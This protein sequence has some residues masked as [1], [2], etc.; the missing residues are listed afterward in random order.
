MLPWAWLHA[1]K[2]YLE[3]AE[4][5]ERHPGM[6]GTINLV[7]SLI[8]QLQEYISG[9]AV[10]PVVALMSKPAEMLTAAEKAFMLDNFFHAQKERLIDRSPRFRELY[11]KANG[12]NPRGH[13]QLED[14]RD[15][16]VQYSLAWTGEISRVREPFKSLVNKDRG[17][18]EEDKRTLAKAQMENVSRIIPLHRELTRRG[19]IEL[20]TSPFYHPI[21]PLL[22]DTES[23]RDAMPDV[24]L[25]THRFQSPEEA[26]EQIRCAREF[27][28]A[29][30][31]NQPDGMWPSEGSLSWDAL[32]LIRKNGFA[33]TATD[34]AVLDHTVHSTAILVRNTSV[35]PQHA[36]YF[37][38]NAKTAEGEIV[39]FFRNHGLS[40]DIGF[41]YPSW[42]AEHATE[43]FVGD[44]LNIR[45]DLLGEYGEDILQ[46]ACISVILDGENCWEFYRNNGYDF[47]DR[48]YSMLCSAPEIQP[49]TFGEV[50]SEA[51][52]DSLP[53]LSKLSAGSWIHGN[54]QIWIGHPEDNAAWD[55]LFLAKKAMDEARAIAR[56]LH[57]TAHTEAIAR[58]EAAHEALKIAEGSDWCWWYGDE[59]VS[60]QSDIFDELYRMHL[61]EVYRILGLNPP[62]DLSHPISGRFSSSSASSRYGAMHRAN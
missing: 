48:L 13:F 5:F 31:G 19:Q 4:H 21:L 11:D 56:K 34:E 35:K 40:D 62:E 39:V 42:N 28:E 2:D 59:N 41:M 60:D 44:I 25:P 53:Q 54:F 1:T 55:A 32:A 27:F 30:F 52:R 57:G 26:Y 7:P 8:K 9:Q 24:G 17:Y 33:W 45:S 14:Y 38:W 12:P 51:K 16:A 22:I 47:L 6:R 20:T 23:A 46:N 49:V 43:H 10:D 50:V 58:I 15:L 37:P 3:M 18:S 29:T 36:K 61:S